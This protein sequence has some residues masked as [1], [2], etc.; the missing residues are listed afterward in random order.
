MVKPQKLGKNTRM[1]FARTKEVLELPNLLEVQKKSYDWFIKDGLN[2]V[3]RDVSPITDYS[4]NLVI[5]FIDFT[6]DDT[7]KYPVG[8]GSEEGVP[9]NLRVPLEGDRDF[10]ELCGSHPGCQVPIQYSSTDLV[11]WSLVS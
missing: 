10:G 6:I 1:S 4:G 2:E 7:P 5:E 3:L 11:N 8:K 9:E